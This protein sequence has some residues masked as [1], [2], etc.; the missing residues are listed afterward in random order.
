MPLGDRFAMKSFALIERALTLLKLGLHLLSLTAMD[1]AT[2]LKE[3]KGRS[4]QAL[5][6]LTQRAL[7]GALL[8]RDGFEVLLSV[9]EVAGALRHIK[10]SA[11]FVDICKLLELLWDLTLTHAPSLTLRATMSQRG[12]GQR[13]GTGHDLPARLA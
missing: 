4:A 3:L 12:T 8:S 2:Y 9:L 10:A 6:L 5:A 1:G 7:R 11:T 13:G